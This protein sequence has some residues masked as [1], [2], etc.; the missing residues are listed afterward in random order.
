[1]LWD[2]KCLLEIY[3]WLFLWI[4]KICLR[5]PPLHPLPSPP[6]SASLCCCRASAPAF[7]TIPR[8]HVN[9]QQP[10]S[11]IRCWEGGE[12]TGKKHNWQQEKG[13]KDTDSWVKP[14]FS[15]E[16][17]QGAEQFISAQSSTLLL[18]FMALPFIAN[19]T[20]LSHQ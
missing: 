6:L 7:H 18:Y 19:Q 3:F 15:A 11:A 9:I 20:E 5:S 14:R 2:W 13:L 4:S 12:T 1:M 16:R 10:A 8:A 17:G